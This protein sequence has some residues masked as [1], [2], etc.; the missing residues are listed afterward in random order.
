MAARMMTTGEGEG[1]REAEGAFKIEGQRLVRV[2]VR[3]R[4]GGGR[5]VVKTSVVERE[6]DGG[7]E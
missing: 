1:G 2:R 5:V 4:K 6:R 3:E 7:G